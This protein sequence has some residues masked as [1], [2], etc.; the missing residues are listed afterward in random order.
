MRS[1]KVLKLILAHTGKTTHGKLLMNNPMGFRAYQDTDI[2]SSQYSKCKS[3]FHS[4]HL[5][6]FTGRIH[7]TTK[8]RVSS[9]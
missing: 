6:D 9:P 7:Y 3:P 5:K 1:K 8:L 4:P 2:N